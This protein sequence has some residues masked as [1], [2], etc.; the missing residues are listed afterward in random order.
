MQ[1]VEGS[2]PFIR[3]QEALARTRASVAYARLHARGG[4]DRAGERQ[5]RDSTGRGG[6]FDLVVVLEALQPV[7]QAYASAE[8]DRDDHD[9]HVVDETGS[10]ELADHARASADADVLAVR[11]LAGPLECL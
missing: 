4:S 3:S 2:S 7:P 11:G 9:V 5:M 1:K 6:G 10:K 8:Q